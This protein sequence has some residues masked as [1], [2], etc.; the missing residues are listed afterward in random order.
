MTAPQFLPGHSLVLLECGAAFFAALLRA[1][2]ASAAEVRLETYI[3]HFDA[4]GEQVAQALERA[5]LRGVRVYLVMDGVGTV[6]VPQQWQQRWSRAGVQW[7]RFLPL[8]RTGLLF[9][10]RWRR[11]HRKLCVVDAGMAFCGGINVLDDWVDPQ[12]GALQSPR[13]DFSVQVSGPLVSDVRSA[14]QQFWQRLLLTRQISQFE[15]DGARQAWQSGDAMEPLVAPSEAAST[16]AMAALVLRD[17]ERN[18]VRIERAYRKAIGDARQEVLIANAYFLPGGKLRRAL[19]LAARRGVRVRLLLQGRYEYFLQYHAT[20][21]VIL[22][23]LNAGVEVYEYQAGFLH[24]KVAVVDGHWAT[25]GSSNLDTLSLLLAREANVVVQD[26]AF[27][28]ELQQRLLAAMR[29]HSAA[30]D[31]YAYARRPWK[32]RCI[33]WAALAAVRALLFVTGRRY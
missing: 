18:R 1:I 26:A 11:L 23:L 22:S 32:Q 6:H 14:M 24:A 9:P 33:D 19:V 28:G 12:Y 29:Q 31:K 10:M 20:R 27:A 30:I 3:F 17:N 8:G 13:Y 2:D 16:G 21:P 25:V 15:F 7:H 5:A 4:T